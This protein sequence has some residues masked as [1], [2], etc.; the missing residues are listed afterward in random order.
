MLNRRSLLR[1]S[2]GSLLL[3]LA[4]GIARATAIT[5]PM[6]GSVNFAHP[7]NRN[8]QFSFLASGEAAATDIAKRQPGVV[9]GAPA[10]GTTAGIGATLTFTGTQNET[11]SNYPTVVENITTLWIVFQT[12]STSNQ[13]VFATASGGS[14]ISLQLVGNTAVV[15]TAAGNL[16]LT[17]LTLSAN[18]PYLLIISTS[19]TNINAILK[20]LDTG[21]SVTYA[22][23]TAAGTPTASDGIFTLGAK[24]WNINTC[25]CSFGAVSYA[26][27]FL[28]LSQMMA[29]AADPWGPWRSRPI[30]TEEMVASASAPGNTPHTRTLLG[31]GK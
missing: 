11:F 25:T 28:P 14:G 9:S 2:A 18:V 4:P 22:S 3:P 19:Y 20:R 16:T 10:G 24:S 23:P 5:R 15:N 6:Q 12:N 26:H 13:D 27:S 1:A 8:L 21:T 17:G 7:A 30:P 29:L 31:V